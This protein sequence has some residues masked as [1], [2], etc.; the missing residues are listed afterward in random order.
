[1]PRMCD[2][3][4]EDRAKIMAAAADMLSEYYRTD[5]EMQ[6]WQALDSVD[7]Y[8]LEETMT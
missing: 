5:P 4:Q 1:M 8:D 7:F 3:S 2:L 6:E